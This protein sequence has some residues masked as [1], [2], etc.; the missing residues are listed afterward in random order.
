MI[1]EG[2]CTCSASGPMPRSR[3]PSTAL[4]SPLL[5]TCCVHSLAFP[6]SPVSSVPA[7][8]RASCTVSAQLSSPPTFHTVV[9]HHI[10]RRSRCCSTGIAS[11]QHILHQFPW[12]CLKAQFPPCQPVPGNPAYSR[13]SSAKFDAIALTFAVTGTFPAP[14]FFHGARSR[15]DAIT[16][17]CSVEGV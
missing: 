16:E 10:S 8:A 11:A 5:K 1:K 2:V 9:L 3:V 15:R 13:V 12:L 17:V 6:E 7:H 14:V 4:K